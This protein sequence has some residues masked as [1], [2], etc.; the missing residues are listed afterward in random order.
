MDVLAKK[1]RVLE[2]GNMPGT[3][4]AA[5][6]APVP[7]SSPCA[8]PTDHLMLERLRYLYTAAWRPVFASVNGH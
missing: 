5:A 7:I 2:Q 3:A 6:A 8:G 1:M 4:M